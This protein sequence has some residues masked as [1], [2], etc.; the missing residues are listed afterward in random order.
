MSEETRHLLLDHRFALEQF[1]HHLLSG[2]SYGN[3]ELEKLVE[4]SG[5]DLKHIQS[6]C[7]GKADMG[8]R[9]METLIQAQWDPAPAKLMVSVT[10]DHLPAKYSLDGEYVELAVDNEQL[11]NKAF[12]LGKLGEELNP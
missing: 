6:F 8:Y 9:D 4:K 3:L 2:L 10:L 5:L 7:L 12:E 1:R 11:L